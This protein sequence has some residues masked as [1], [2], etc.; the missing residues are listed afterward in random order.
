MHISH[1]I[2]VSVRP[3]ILVRLVVSLSSPDDPVRSRQY[4]RRDREADLLG[5]LQID[6]Q[7]ELRW[8][9]DRKIGGI[10]AFQYFVHI[11]GRTPET[12]VFVGGIRQQPPASTKTLPSDIKGIRF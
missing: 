12:M 3:L 10:C 2:E 7:L 6:H 11:V 8:L 9:L 1:R 4:V 5:G